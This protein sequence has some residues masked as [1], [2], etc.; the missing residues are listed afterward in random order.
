MMESTKKISWKQLFVLSSLIFGMFFGSGNLIFP[1][2]L[3]QLAGN[4]WFV[5]AL[6]F[7][8]S[9]ALFPFLAI[10]A[11]VVTK[12]DGL[13]DL[14]RPVGK[15]YAAVFL[16]LVHLTIGPFFG[17][18]RTAA[19]AFE[20][21]FKPFLAEKYWSLGMFLFTAAFFAL[22]YFLTLHQ[23]KLMTYVGK[24]LN[25]IF[26]VLLAVV[27]LISFFHPMGNLN[28]AATTDYAHHPLTNGV[29][30]GY[31]TVDAVAL[32]AFS[33]TVVHAVKAM[34][35]QK[36]E[37]K[38]TAQAGL[39][40]VLLEVVIY[41]GLVLVGAMSLNHFQLSDNGGTALAQIVHYYLSDFGSVFLG[42]LVTLGVFTTAMGL[43]VSFAQDFH[44]LFP[45]VSYKNWLRL[46]T[47]VSFVVANAGLDRII[48]WSLP[49]LM[50]L[51]PLSLAL[52]LLSLTAKYFDKNPFVY[53]MTIAF[54]LVPAVLDMLANAPQVVATQP[55]VN[56]LLTFYHHYLPF[57]SLGLGWVV[58]T[59]VGF[60]LSFLYVKM[61]P[62]LALDTK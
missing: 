2:H 39:F 37:A 35:F 8:I 49:V 5:A 27:F 45:R 1:V 29:L 48:Q 28:H 47:F 42:V 30:Q 16:I 24:Y 56:A 6:G 51:Y 44:K 52:I 46:T 14:A 11:V 61:T 9:G 62:R 34:G 41:F 40:S 25:T 60:C 57:A 54:T 15:K 36:N 21:G 33:V 7:A 13:Y 50:L 18:P 59:F 53:Q 10:L 58:P 31:N 55:I 20:I 26:L 22:A 43:V 17:T 3:G 4:H 12:S 23:N 19:T 38:I 32:L